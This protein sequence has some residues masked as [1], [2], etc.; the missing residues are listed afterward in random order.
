[1]GGERGRRGPGRARGP[2]V[3]VGLR[4]RAR[5]G[6]QHG[7]SRQ[8]G[9]GARQAPRP[10][11]GREY[12]V[13][14]P[15]RGVPGA[16]KA[17]LRPGSAPPSRQLGRGGSSRVPG[18]GGPPCPCPGGPGVPLTVPRA[19]CWD[20]SAAVGASALSGVPGTLPRAML[21]GPGRTEGCSL[22]SGVH[23]PPQRG[24]GAS[25][26]PSGALPRP[27]NPGAHP[28]ARGSAPHAQCSLC[29]HSGC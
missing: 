4:G 14:A 12:R 5:L 8:A 26:R 10:L 6:P 16:L 29:S 2:G 17:P 27:A 15:G 25:S 28:P 13:R 20:P 23:P 1:M 21:R 7:G 11:F 3:A 24:A 19:G 18:A 9:A 22:P